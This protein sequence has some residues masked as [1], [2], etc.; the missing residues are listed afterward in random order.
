MA[1]QSRRSEP[2]GNESLEDWKFIGA[3][4]FGKVYKA[5]HKDWG[6]DV[7]IKLIHHA[8]GAVMSLCQEAN[9]MDEA[10]CPYV[11]R[12]C[13]IYEGYPP[14]GGP[15][16]QRGIVM[17]FMGRGSIQTLQ[18]D[19][20]GP[21]PW[22]LAFRFAHHVALGMNFLH[23]KKILHQDLKPCN[24]LLNDDLNAK[25]ADFGLSMVSTSALTSNT[26]MTGVVGGS[27]KYM[28]PES[29]DISYKP[30]RAFDVY[31]YG[32]LLWSI[33][34]GEEPYP[35][36][37]RPRVELRIPMGDRPP[38]ETIEQME[39][40]G[41]KDLIDLMKRCWNENPSERPTFECCRE[42]TESVLS[43]HEKDVPGAVYQVLTQLASPQSHQHFNNNVVFRSAPRMRKQSNDTVD[44]PIRVKN[45]VSV[46][47]KNLTVADKAKF[48]D[49]NRAVLIQSVSEVLAIAEEL[50][51]MVHPEAYSAIEAKTTSYGQMRVI[52][53][54]TLRSG[55]DVVKAAFYDALKKHHPRLVERPGG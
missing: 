46:P 51:D 47:T 13:G 35:A 36:A 3:G 6:F 29:F 15:S 11:L 8:D 26:E 32:V 38:C 7:A 54:K 48:V 34:N 22:P 19:L 23:Q 40:E 25:V 16:M 53:Q 12:R 31:S 42:V 43:Q 14:K 2:V 30:V 45:P 4:G 21:P 52:Y 28:P 17:E 44:H 10:A 9:H 49:E 24:V 27:Y 18:K 50:G 41:L 20:S 55:G 39:V 37:D 1:L 5:R 33:L